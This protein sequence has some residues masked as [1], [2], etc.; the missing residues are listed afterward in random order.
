[1]MPGLEDAISLWMK[2][3][4]GF[5]E[6]AGAAYIFILGAVILRMSMDCSNA[7]ISSATS[8]MLLIQ[9]RCDQRGV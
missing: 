7:A 5:R 1:M 3:H 6:R 8:L 2:A 9:L 4:R